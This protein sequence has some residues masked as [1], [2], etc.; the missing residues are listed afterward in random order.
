[1]KFQIGE[2]IWFYGM[3]YT[4]ESADHGFWESAGTILDWTAKTF[5]PPGDPWN[6]TTERYFINGGKFFFR[7]QKD[8]TMFVLRWA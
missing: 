5:G 8:L 4:I 6:S 3:Y 7:D 1:M 2:F